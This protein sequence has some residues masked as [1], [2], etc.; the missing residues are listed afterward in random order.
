VNKRE[1]W[2]NIVLLTTIGVISVIGFFTIYST[3]ISPLE[4]ATSNIITKH[5]L[6]FTIALLI[7]YFL[8]K[9]DYT[10]LKETQ[11][12]VILGLMGILSLVGVLFFGTEIN[13]A[14]R[15]F[16]IGGESGGISVQPS[17]FMKIILIIVTSYIYTRKQKNN[18][19]AKWLK[20]LTSLL[21]IGII[22]ALIFIQPDAGT[23]L[24]SLS[25]WALITFVGFPN[26]KILLYSMPLF[27]TSAIGSYGFYIG[28]YYFLA[29][30][31]INLI[32]MAVVFIRQN[33]KN[34]LN[35][36]LL[37]F[38]SLLLLIGI[39][40]GYSAIPFWESD[41][42]ADYQKDRIENFV[43]PTDE[44]NFHVNQSRVAIGSGR[45]FGKG[46]GH[47]TQS[48]LRFLPEHQT[49]FIFAAFAEEFG[50]IG[51]SILI[52]L[53]VILIVDI[54]Y[55]STKVKEPFGSLVIYGIGVKILLEV[56]INLGMNL[57][58]T[59]ATGL[60]LPFISY[61]GSNLLSNFIGAGLIQS[62]YMRDKNF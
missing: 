45:L 47:G 31:I 8:Q 6:F 14:T 28:N 23:T 20:L 48:K 1:S 62:I 3:S 53:Y 41:I 33:I 12:I 55:L 49:D 25:I 61:G 10:L 60:P 34:V 5:F 15:W 35:T 11:I 16:V 17:E 29:P 52:L 26:P 27:I 43:N 18:N 21:F 50:F 38:C 32:V 56:F 44:S 39:G 2:A 37:G 9:L 19:L 42:L 7:A 13:G 30:L 46:F 57:G 36:E 22:A 40:L 24:I 54:F 51:S 4:S 59:P 58:I